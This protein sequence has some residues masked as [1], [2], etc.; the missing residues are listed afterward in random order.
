MSDIEELCLI[1]SAPA[2]VNTT[3]AADHLSTHSREE[4]IAAIESLKTDL[5]E[6][7]AKVEAIWQS[8]DR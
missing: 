1:C 6:A 2:P 4:L 8:D 5:A 7:I 3:A